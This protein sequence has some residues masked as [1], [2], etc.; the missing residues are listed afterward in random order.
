MPASRLRIL[1]VLLA[2]VALLLPGLGCS[3]IPGL[4]ATDGGVVFAK[5]PIYGRVVS[6]DGKPAAGVSVKAYLTNSTPLTQGAPLT[7]SQPLVGNNSMGYRRIAAGGAATTDAAGRFVLAAVDAGTYNLEA[8]AT[9]TSKAWKAS[10]QFKAGDQVEVGDMRL[11]PTGHIS[12]KVRSDDASVTNFV[13]TQVYIPG[14]SYHATTGPDGKYTISNVPVGDFPLRAF[15]S[16][17]GDAELEGT[18]AVEANR[19]STGPDLILKNI[20]PK[21]A[22]LTRKATDDLT[23]N[24]APGAEVDIH[25][26][27][28]GF[29]R[30]TKF[31]VQFSGSLA[32]APTRVSDSLIRVKV[33]SGA[34]T[35]NL[36]VIVGGL[37]SNALKFRAIKSLALTQGALTVGIGQTRDLSDLVLVKDTNG[38]PIKEFLDGEKV[39]NAGPNLTWSASSAGF[40]GL[41]EDGLA[42]G[43]S[44]GALQV[45]ARAGDLT[46]VVLAVTVAQAGD[47]NPTP[48]P[49]S[50]P[51]GNPTTQ[52]TTQP[53]AQPSQQPDDLSTIPGDDDGPGLTG[54]FIA[55][56]GTRINNGAK[57]TEIE[58]RGSGFDQGTIVVQFD[59]AS[60][61]A[62]ATHQVVDAGTIRATIPSSLTFVSTLRVYRDGK[63]SP[64][65]RFVPIESFSIRRQGTLFLSVGGTSDF[66]QVEI[67]AKGPGGETLIPLGIAYGNV[68]LSV[69]N[70]RYKVSDPTGLSVDDAGKI[71]ALKAGTFT[72]TVEA[73]SLTSRTQNVSVN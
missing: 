2:V 73:G 26:S 50:N 57:G 5:G 21:L 49:T 58:I 59:G 35:G 38:D 22:K 36:T 62:V 27:N 55:G 56:T 32:E 40:L 44:L 34:L 67:D 23:D 64:G 14:S 43:L 17:L 53:S 3:F 20:V 61:Q 42:Q 47:T 54:A 24:A 66:A 52:P 71:T 31:Q 28:F 18:V 25:G 60:A 1:V 37:T 33:P 8:A 4:G 39:V 15:Q 46:P 63:K 12:G 9:E 72:L 51:T 10:V 69:L 7:N 29:A 68:K 48:G 70:L 6:A 19:T 30:G 41:T 13:N 16:D 11:L 45:T 65:W